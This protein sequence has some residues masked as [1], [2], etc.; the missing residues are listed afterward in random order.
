MQSVLDIWILPIVL[1]ELSVTYIGQT[2]R[3]TQLLKCLL[4]FFNEEINYQ[5]ILTSA[6]AQVETYNR[7]ITR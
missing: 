1:D 7:V 4:L 6:P 2:V 5:P 3:P